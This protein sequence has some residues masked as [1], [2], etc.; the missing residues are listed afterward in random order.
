[1]TLGARLKAL[2]EILKSVLEADKL[3]ADAILSNYMRGRRYIGSKDRRFLSDTLYSLLRTRGRLLFFKKDFEGDRDTFEW[4]VLLYAFLNLNLSVTALISLCDDTPYH[5]SSLS[6]KEIS[7]LK[8]I[9]N[10]NPS[11]PVWALLSYPETLEDLLEEAFGPKTEDYF[12][13]ELNFFQKEAPLDLRINTLKALR[14]EILTHFSL[15]GVEAIATPYSS[16]GVRLPKKILLTQDSEFLKGSFEI[17]DEGSQLIAFLLGA[18]PGEQILDFCAG[19]GGKTLAIAA[20]MKNKG[21]LIA[22]DINAVRLQKAA[23]RLK[24]AGVHMVKTMILEDK[25]IKRQK[26]RFDR[27]LV[28]APCSGSGTWRRNPDQKWKTTPADIRELQEL[29]FAILKRAASTLKKGGTL[30]YATCSLFKLENEDVIMMF[31]D[32]PVG[33]DF[34]RIEANTLLKGPNILFKGPYLKMSPYQ[35]QTDGFFAAVLRKG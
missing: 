32:S 8:K 24:R 34:S 12:K 19:A 18:K 27:V 11:L 17:Q 22:G 2:A 5:L 4:E 23:G 30:V 15:E 29:Q 21:T 3:P 7:Y 25:W 14:E 13:E 35:T 1:M 33:Q 16:I 26:D 31:L 6:P 9:E 28:D 10:Q 20:D